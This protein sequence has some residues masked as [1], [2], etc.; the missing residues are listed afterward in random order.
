MKDEVNFDQVAEAY[1]R[2]RCLP[3]QHLERLVSQLL[4]TYLYPSDT[5]LDVGCGTGQLS[6]PFVK[7]GMAV[8]GVDISD[9]MGERACKK[10]PEYTFVKASVV[11]LPFSDDTFS[12]AICSKLFMHVPDWQRAC[13]EIMRVVKPGGYFMNVNEVGA[14]ANKL[15]GYFTEQA[16]ALGYASRFRGE[17]DQEKVAE[18]AISLGARRLP[19]PVTDTEYE[20]TISYEDVLVDLENRQ[21]AEFWSMS[22]ADYETCLGRARTWLRSASERSENMTPHLHI[23]LFQF[24]NR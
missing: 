18:Y 20:R 22:D 15:R 8:T 1:D 13:R 16:E 9:N 19:S 12:I 5:C 4:E 7:A 6:A 11:D 10:M 21:F 17:L 24:P 23:Y 14:F 3:P 2:S